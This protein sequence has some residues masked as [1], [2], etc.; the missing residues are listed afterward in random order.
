MTLHLAGGGASGGGGAARVEFGQID[1]ADLPRLQAY[2][3][4]CK[5]PVRVC[6]RA[7]CARFPCYVFWVKTCKSK[8]SQPHTSDAP[9]PHRPAPT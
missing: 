6:L 2:V 1:Q 7:C 3:A 9:Q 5:L 4:E 8:L